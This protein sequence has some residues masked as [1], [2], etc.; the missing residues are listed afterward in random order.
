MAYLRTSEQLDKAWE[1]V[2]ISL[3]EV[4]KEQKKREDKFDEAYL[5]EE[6]WMLAIASKIGDEARPYLTEEE[7]NEYI[8][9]ISEMF[10]YGAIS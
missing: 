4:R 8:D 5:E 7:E 9:T 1:N 10:I 6:E 3:A 2:I